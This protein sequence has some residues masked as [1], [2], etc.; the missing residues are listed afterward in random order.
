MKE[1][2]LNPS[3]LN[4]I[5]S[6]LISRDHKRLF[7]IARYTGQNIRAICN[8][9]VLNL[10]NEQGVLMTHIKFSGLISGV[11]FFPIHEP[12]KNELMIYS[13]ENFVYEDWLFPSSVKKEKPIVPAT[14][15]KCLKT[16]SKKAELEHLYVSSKMIRDAFIYELYKSGMSI[17]NIK[18]ILGITSIPEILTRISPEIIDF[19][20]ALQNIFG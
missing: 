9:K 16:A 4:L 11:H 10:Y 7:A 8:L 17:N 12:L 18:E 13:L 19:R 6:K 3:Q 14:F 2:I 1:I 15:D 5:K 20:G